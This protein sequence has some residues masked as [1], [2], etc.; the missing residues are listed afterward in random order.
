MEEKHQHMTMRSGNDGYAGSNLCLQTI[1]QLN[2][3]IAG[4]G[5]DQ[6]HKTRLINSDKY[7][8][9]LSE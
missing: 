6:Q 8:R 2:A 4:R 9:C 7:R 3:D 5:A 1:E